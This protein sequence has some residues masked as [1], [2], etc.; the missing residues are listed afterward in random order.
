MVARKKSWIKPPQTLFRLTQIPDS[1]ALRD[2]KS[3]DLILSPETE[4]EKWEGEEEVYTWAK[5]LQA[6][7]YD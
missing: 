1:K 2:V 4:E 7:V 3:A 5:S 6:A